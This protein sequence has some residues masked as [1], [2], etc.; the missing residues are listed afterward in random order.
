MT[1]TYLKATPRAILRGIQDLSRRAPS[2]EPELLPQHLPH[3][4]TLAER[5][6]TTAHIAIG[7][8]LKQLYGDGILDLNSP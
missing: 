2:I 5:G 7:D 1:T 8:A 4:F 6:R 3:F